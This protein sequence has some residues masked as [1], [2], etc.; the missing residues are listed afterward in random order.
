MR[1]IKPLLLA[2]V[3]ILS[4]PAH[5]AATSPAVREEIDALLAKLQRSGCQ[6]NRNG[7]WHDA[8]DAQLHLQKKLAYLERK[9]AP[10]STER[11]IE[12]AGS[13]SSVTGHP[14]LV[15]CGSASPIE[16]RTWLLNE[17]KAIRSQKNGDR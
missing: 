10:I 14:Y 7:S 6:F 16:S 8:K 3:F 9:N 17:L 2:F 12:L 13:G 5:T 15:R 4:M 11:F 1:G